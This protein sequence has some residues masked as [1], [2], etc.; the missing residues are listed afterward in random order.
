LPELKIKP[1]LSFR[2]KY[3]FWLYLFTAFL[4]LQLPIISVPFKWLESYFH[5]ISHG[6]SALVTGGTI[7]QIQLFPNG[8]GLCTT[9]GGL[10]FVISFMGYAGAIFWGTLIYAIASVHQRIAQVFSGL[11][12]CLLILSLV[13]WVRDILS[14]IIVTVLLVIFV[15]QFKLPKSNYLQMAL[16]LTGILVLVNSLYSPWYLIDGRSLGD[17]AALAELTMIP[18]FIWVLI[19]SLLGLLSLVILAKKSP[20]TH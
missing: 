9:R 14:F 11:V 1:R 15:A 19:W 20:S 3:Q 2:Q 6:I 16:K 8:A 4:I 13:F 10:S 12:I 17:G 18:E 5:E 7:L